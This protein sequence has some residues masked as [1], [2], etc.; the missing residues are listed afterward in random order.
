MSERLT[1][2]VLLPH[3]GRSPSADHLLATARQAESLGFDKL[4]VRDHLY[5]PPENRE[6][7]G[8]TEDVF[9]ESFQTLA[10]V[11]SATD[12]VGLGTAIANPHRHPLKLSQHYATLE[13]LADGPVVAGVGAGTFRG[14]FD[15]V[16][17]PFEERGTMADET[18]QILRRT[19]REEH[20]DF[21]GEVFSFEDVTLEPRPG[22]AVPLWYGGLS[23]IAVKRAVRHADGWFPGR[24]TLEKLDERLSLLREQE[25]RHDRS[26]DRAYV[27]TYSVAADRERAR[28][29]IDFP[30]LIDDINTILREDYETVDDIDGTFAAGAPD[31]V[32]SQLRRLEVR[33]FDHVVLDMRHSFDE[34]GRMLE[35]TA[36]EVL[37]AFS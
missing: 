6:H 11:S 34:L 3:F 37:P 10:A 20:V 23:P 21:A 8:I 14:E 7:G 25:R 9:L 31:D 16:D 2:G 36:D 30:E 18:L 22:D 4:W 1:F 12:D 26:L 17:L 24:M 19:F 32:V 29:R 13:Y 33:G 27:T 35:L 28:S 15:A 5:I